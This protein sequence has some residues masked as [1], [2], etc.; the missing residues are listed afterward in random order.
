MAQ[1]TETL[2][3][4]A[5]TAIHHLSRIANILANAARDVVTELGEMVSDVAEVASTKRPEQV[6]PPVEE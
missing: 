1:E 3:E 4:V 6:E 5:E 2:Q